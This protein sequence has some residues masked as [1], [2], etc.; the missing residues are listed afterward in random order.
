MLLRNENEKSGGK[1]IDN[2]DTACYN[3]ITGRRGTAFRQKNKRQVN[4]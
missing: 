1:S 3:T 4:E 2:P